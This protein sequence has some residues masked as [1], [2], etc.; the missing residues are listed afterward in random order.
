MAPKPI[1]K[2][3]RKSNF[4]FPPRRA[5]KKSAGY[6]LFSARDCIIP[7]NNKAY[8]VETDLC[9]KLPKGCYGQISGRSGLALHH[10]AIIDP[11]YRGPITVILFNHSGQDYIISRGDRIAQLILVRIFSPTVKEVKTLDKTV[12]EVKT[13]DKTIRNK[14]G[15]GST[16]I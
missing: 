1:L 14:K 6:D 12:K 11:D 13:L 8:P 4:A 2:Y 5:T 9:I 7:G 10:W 16:G 15:L 3:K